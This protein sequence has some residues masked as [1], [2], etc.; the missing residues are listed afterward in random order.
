MAHPNEDLLRRGYAAFSNGDMETVGSLLADDVQ[1]H[2]P[3][4]SPIS[5]DYKGKEEV[6]GFFAKLIEMTGGKLT[7]EVHDI[8]ANDEHGIVLVNG[9]AERDGKRLVANSVHVH[10]I[11]NGKTAELWDHPTDLYELDE[12]WS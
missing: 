5:G 12:F 2:V 7:V 11:R 3:G 8:L 4:K 10:H 6:F 9:T 1:W